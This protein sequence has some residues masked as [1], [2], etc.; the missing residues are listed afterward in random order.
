MSMARKKKRITVSDILRDI[1]GDNSFDC[2]MAGGSNDDL[3][4][5]SDCSYD[6]DSSGEGST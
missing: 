1:N 6:S 4:M 3:G 5:N 2:G